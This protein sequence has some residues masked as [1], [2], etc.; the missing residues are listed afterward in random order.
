MASD[1]TYQIVYSSEMKATL[2]IE[3]VANGFTVKM[4][5]DTFVFRTKK[6]A[7][8]HIN[9]YLNNLYKEAK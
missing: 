7:F 6:E 5:G 4:S 1:F 8:K 3:K 9:K 2:D